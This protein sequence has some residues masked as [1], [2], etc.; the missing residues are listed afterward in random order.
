[1]T[2]MAERSQSPIPR[3]ILEEAADWFVEFRVDEIDGGAR[4]R[5]DRWLR[6]SPQHVQAYLDLATTYASLPADVAGAAVDLDA[7]IARARADSAADVIPLTTTSRR[8][9]AERTSRGFRAAVSIA[10]S[11]A[12]AGLLGWLGWRDHGVYST[13]IGQERSITLVDGSVVELNA[14]SRIRVSYSKTE[15]LVDL[16]AGEAFFRVTSNPRYPFLVRGGDFVVRDVGTEFDINREVTRTVVTVL[17]GRIELSA[18]ND[19]H[20]QI[21]IQ[22]LAGGHS[23]RPGVSQPIMLSAG[24]SV[25]VGSDGTGSV[26]RGADVAEAAAWRRHELNFDSLPL[27]DVVQEFNRYNRRQ[28]VIVSPRLDALEISGVY[29]STDPGSFLRFLREQPGIAVEESGGEIRIEQLGG[30]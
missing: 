2:S 19:G 6:Q 7:L 9:P 15:R 18:A 20:A 24:Q 14:R 16:I 25:V 13:G 8:V 21:P 28:L 27:V 29:S 11:I 12:I 22:A 26:R 23:E 4:E 30:N 17:E 10:A 1:M 3:Q 5:F